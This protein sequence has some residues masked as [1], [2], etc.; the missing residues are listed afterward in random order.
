M[1]VTTVDEGL[2]QL[3]L[4]RLFSFQRSTSHSAYSVGAPSAQPEN[5]DAFSV[6]L[7]LRNTYTRSSGALNRKTHVYRVDGMVKKSMKGACTIEVIYIPYSPKQNSWN[8]F[9]DAYTRTAPRAHE[10]KHAWKSLGNR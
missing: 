1:V 9:V 10:F 5:F 3:Q 6:P 7:C 8:L 4:N 2:S